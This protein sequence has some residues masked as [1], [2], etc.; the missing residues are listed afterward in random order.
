MVG[1]VDLES[2]VEVPA[3]VDDLRPA[4]WRE[5]AAHD[6]D[7]AQ[8]ALGHHD[9]RDEDVDVP[10]GR[11]H[12]H[13]GV[14]R[15]DFR[16][17]AVTAGGEQALDLIVQVSCV[18]LDVVEYDDVDHGDSPCDEEPRGGLIITFLMAREA[19]HSHSETESYGELT[20]GYGC[21][22]DVVMQE[23]AGRWG[24]CWLED[25]WWSCEPKAS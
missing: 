11:E 7:A 24:V 16:D 2:L 9:V 23:A 20:V 22:C 14:E 12:I 13:E 25:S 21:A 1:G 15:D 5:E 4:A 3:D 18:L 6:V 10:P 8:L 17:E 19:A